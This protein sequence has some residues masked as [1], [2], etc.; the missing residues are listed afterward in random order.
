[1]GKQ[2]LKLKRIQDAE[3]KD[4]K[5]LVR[6]DYNV[7]LEGTT[8]TDQTRI[9]E[10]LPTLKHLLESNCKIILLS[11]LGRPKGVVDDKFSLKPV[12]PVLKQMLKTQVHF[13]VD[14]MGPDAEKLVA[15]A[16]PG[17]VILLENLRFHPEEEKNDTSFAK[18]LAG[19]GDYFIQ[20]A[21]GA[22]HR[23]HA[24][25]V[26]IPKYLPSAIGYLVQKELE[27]LDR[28]L[29]NPQ[30]PFLALLGGAKISDKIGVIHR[31]L[32][33]VNTLLIGGGMTYTFLA[34]Q[35]VSVG[36]SL[37]EKDKIQDA[38][39]IIEEAY[40]RNVAFLV[41]ADHVMVKEIRPGAPTLVSQAM[42][43]QEDWIGVDIGPH[44][45]EL[46]SE[47]IAE[48]KTIFWNGP[49]GIFEME[50]FSHGSVEIAK[51]LAQATEAGAVTVVGGGDTLAVLAKAGAADKMTHC[52]TGGGAS[53]E[54]LEGKVLPGLSALSQE[55]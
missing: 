3:L 33:R 31:L 43:V 47:K 36:K 38:E 13:G 1:M 14:C 49:M 53:L 26:G 17:E 15:K 37:V 44:T 9:Q 19:L 30:R 27:F 20:D 45:V 46:F 4:K 40:N 7:P 5:V 21:F 12:V 8:V 29:G 34:A 22:L 39:K 6:V 50:P 48:S 41:P 55:N 32:E 10:T 18:A 52:S 25:T 51:I 23:S 2:A 11:H 54:L 24:S 16:K 28:T 35:G 42:A